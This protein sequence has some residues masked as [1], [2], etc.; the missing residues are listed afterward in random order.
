MTSVSSEDLTARA[1]IRNVA[2]AMFAEQGFEAATTRGIAAQ[3]GVSPA[4]LRHHFGSKQGLR[5]EVDRE[6]SRALGEALQE[7]GAELESGD[8]VAA[9]G[10]VSARLFGADPHL[11]GYLR[12]VLLEDS[13]TS[14]R[15]FDRL[16]AGTRAELD[17]LGGLGALRSDADPVWAAYQVL[18]LILGPLLLEPV[19]RRSL[20]S[21]PFAAEVLR[22]RSEANQ[23]LLRHG[24]FA[25][26]S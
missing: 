19:L 18:F 7:V 9:L 3:A 14:S 25:I 24:M 23:R 4:L 2:L 21:E 11:R 16:L 5:E 10:E 26:D 22:A 12:R 15:L 8:L 13:D 17:R 1:K 20:S 6:V